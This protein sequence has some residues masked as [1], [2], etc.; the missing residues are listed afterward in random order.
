MRIDPKL[1]E[2]AAGVVRIILKTKNTAKNDELNSGDFGSTP[3][4]C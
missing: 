1:V 4:W 3:P 2:L